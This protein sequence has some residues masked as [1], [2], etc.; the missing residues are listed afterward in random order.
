MS[1]GWCL[2]SPTLQGATLVVAIALLA[3]GLG[4]KGGLW[5]R[6]GG[7][8][9]R[10]S[11]SVAWVVAVLSACALMLRPFGPRPGEGTATAVLVTDAGNAGVAAPAAVNEAAS[12]VFVLAGGA[13]GGTPGGVAS[14]GGVSRDSMAS[15]E[16]ATVLPDARTLW[17]LQPGLA[18]LRVQGHGLDAWDWSGFGGRLLFAAPPLPP[19]IST[20]SWSRRIALGDRLRVEGRVVG[21]PSG[22][23]ASSAPSVTVTLEGPGGPEDERV[24]AA[25]PGGS[26]FVLYAL[27]R[28]PGRWLYRLHWT[29]DR[30][31]AGRASGVETLDVAVSEPRPAAVLVLE[32]APR[33][34]TRFLKDWLAAAGGRVAVRSVISRDRVRTESPAGG[35]ALGRRLDGPSFDGFDAVVADPAA[36]AAL[37][38]VE[39]AALRSAVERGAGLVIQMQRS[40]TAGAADSLPQD[41][42]V[43]PPWSRIA[44]LD[45]LSARLEWMGAPVLPALDLEAR[46]FGGDAATLARDTSG[47]RLAVAT[48]LGSGQVA[49]TLV[50]DTYRWVLESNAAAH[51]AWWSRLLSAVARSS[52]PTG[53]RWL[54]PSGP[55]VVDR[56]LELTLEGAASLPGEP[57]ARLLDGDGVAPQTLALRQDALDRGRFTATVWPRRAG[58]FRVE[59]AGGAALDLHAA[60]ATDWT[61]WRAAERQRATLQRAAAGPLSTASAATTGS[62][63]PLPRWP[64]FALM[65]AGLAWLWGDERLRG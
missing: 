26:S 35:A 29:I 3:V 64:F 38:A 20:A 14:A 22:A 37:S 16:S 56:P 41:F 30:G 31:A 63:P 57:A 25:A 49:W 11:R 51:R 23:R 12:P 45:V 4:G 58:W 10:W 59:N 9:T 52:Q 19:G 15:V 18:A 55:I 39:R 5:R 33:F 42:G 34:E 1:G 27:P 54:S 24:L 60:P 53:G 62:R 7:R 21:D 48:P 32:A 43:A 40:P 47:R 8:F 13:P 50:H 2:A 46:E 44:G 6:A 61:T 36:L 17:R 65:L 28:A